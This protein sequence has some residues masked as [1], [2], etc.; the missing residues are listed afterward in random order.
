MPKGAFARDL[1]KYYRIEFDCPR[2]KARQKLGLW[3]N[4]FGLHCVATYRFGQWATRLYHRQFLL[5][6]L[7]RLLHAMLNFTMRVIHHVELNVVGIGPGL[8]IGHASGIFIGASSIG[9]NLSIT[10]NVTIGLGHSGGKKGKPH[11]GH[12]VWIGTGT[13]V[14]GAITVGDNVTITP[15][16]YLSRSIP[17]ACLVGGNPG[18][19]LAHNYDNQKL[20]PTTNAV[21]ERVVPHEQP[22]APTVQAE[23]RVLAE[24]E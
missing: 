9:D 3:M 8:Y 18:R 21:G 14:S 20:L 13:V 12:N 2:P 10:H 7:P 24:G 6:L 17:G 16:T 11:I 5:G 4:N 15:G 23:A 22:T 1:E 19:V